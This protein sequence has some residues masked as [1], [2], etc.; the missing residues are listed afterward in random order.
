MWTSH[1]QSILQYIK[2]IVTIIKDQVIYVNFNLKNLLNK[3]V[4]SS[5][6]VQVLNWIMADHMWAVESVRLVSPSSI[7]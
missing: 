1:L 7:G 6:K 3:K 4:K 5:I 2:N